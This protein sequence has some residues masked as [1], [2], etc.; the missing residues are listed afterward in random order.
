MAHILKAVWFE[1]ENFLC[2]KTLWLLTA[3]YTVFAFAVCLF[4]DLRQSYFSD[5]ESVPVML[6]NFIAPVFLAVIVIGICSPAFAGDKENHVNQIPSACL[7]GKMGRSIIK[8]HA[9]ILLSLAGHLMLTVITFIA[10]S[11]CN[12]FDGNLKVTHVGTELRL[13][14]VWSAWRHIAFSFLCLAA[15]C[16]ILTLFVLFFSSIT[17]TTIAAVSVSSIFVLFECLFNRF[18]FPTV[19][20]E[21]NIWVFFRPYFFFV[22]ETVHISPLMN[23]LLLSAAFLPICISAAW[24]IAKKGT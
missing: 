16:T 22:T 24:Q 6:L 8:T 21:Y 15:A 19:M 18:S 11:L 23:L 10:A 2:K 12:L 5:I 7:I 20:Q 14:P 13:T 9:A 3:A 17:K 4:P 1:L